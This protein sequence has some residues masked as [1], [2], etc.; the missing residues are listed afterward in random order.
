[1][2]S[3]KADSH[4]PILSGPSNPKVLAGTSFVCTQSMDP[5]QALP[6]LDPRPM[7]EPVVVSPDGGQEE[8]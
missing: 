8:R 6:F 4:L 3:A 1:M 2:A 5:P 7:S